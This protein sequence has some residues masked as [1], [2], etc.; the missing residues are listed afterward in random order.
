[1]LYDSL[2]AVGAMLYDGLCAVGAMLY[3]GLCAVVAMLYDGLFAVGAMLYDG[4]NP[5][6]CSV[7]GS[8]IHYTT[9]QPLIQ[10]TNY[11]YT[12][13]YVKK[14]MFYLQILIIEINNISLPMITYQQG[15]HNYL[16]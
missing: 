1:M 10:S 15:M 11:H 8:Y 13:N 2:C 9:V 14:E 4:K 16:I 5:N 12:G 3:D 6:Y 7:C